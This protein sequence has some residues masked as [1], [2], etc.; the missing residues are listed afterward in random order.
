MSDVSPRPEP[1]VRRAAR[2]GRPAGGYCGGG[3]LYREGA[4]LRLRWCRHTKAGAEAEGDRLCCKKLIQ[5][6]AI[7][8]LQDHMIAHL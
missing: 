5:R 3:V 4:R 7:D 1:N 2:R 8:Q 6:C